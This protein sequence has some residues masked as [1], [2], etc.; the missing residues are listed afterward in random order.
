MLMLTT[1]QT[2]IFLFGTA[3]ILGFL[4]RDIKALLN[5]PKTEVEGVATGTPDAT[6]ELI[7]PPIEPPK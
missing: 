1:L 4:S 3:F 6:A 5:P 2:L 7:V